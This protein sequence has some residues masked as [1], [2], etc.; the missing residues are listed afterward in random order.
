MKIIRTANESEMI[1]DFLKGEIN[2]NRFNSELIK[3]LRQLGLDKDIIINGDIS[4]Q[5]EN[6]NRLK[7]MSIF[8]GYPDKELFENFPIIEDK[9]IIN[10]L[11]SFYLTLSKY[12][13]KTRVCKI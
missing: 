1:L 7:I 4:N 13:Y 6:N 2:S 9:T 5:E 11:V 10:W 12:A 3:V 8:R